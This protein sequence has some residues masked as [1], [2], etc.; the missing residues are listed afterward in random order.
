M[1]RKV[2]VAYG[3]L[4]KLRRKRIMTKANYKTI[5]GARRY[6]L[7][8]AKDFYMAEDVVEKI[9]NAES[10]SEIEHIWRDAIDNL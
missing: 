5:N 1:D 4:L 6:F 3:N 7:G 8:L 10:V 9:R 2:R